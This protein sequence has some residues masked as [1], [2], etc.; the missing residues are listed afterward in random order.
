MKQASPTLAKATLSLAVPLLILCMV[1]LLIVRARPANA[2]NTEGLQPFLA[3]N[4]A[5]RPPCIM[6]IEPGIT[7]IEVA[8]VKLRAHPWVAGLSGSSAGPYTSPF[9]VLWRWSGQQ[10]DFIDASAEGLALGDSTGVVT[11]IRIQ[12]TLSYADVWQALGPP[13]GGNVVESRT[14]LLH[15]LLYHGHGQ[16]IVIDQTGCPVNLYGFWSHPILLHFGPPFIPFAD[17]YPNWGARRRWCR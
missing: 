16:V 14:Y 1:A 13:D 7:P 9:Q 12:T 2:E 17:D 8:R 11:S 15:A 4:G 6:G 3:P 5:C 10:P